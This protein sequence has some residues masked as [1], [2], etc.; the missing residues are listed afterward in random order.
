MVIF[1]LGYCDNQVLRRVESERLI[2]VENH[3]LVLALLHT[4]R[5][6]IVRFTGNRDE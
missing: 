5:T 2:K 4:Y 1:R 6:V 3:V